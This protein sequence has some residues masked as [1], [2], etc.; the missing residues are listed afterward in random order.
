M[1]FRRCLFEP[2][3]LQEVVFVGFSLHAADKLVHAPVTH[4]SAICMVEVITRKGKNGAY[5]H[6][7]WLAWARCAAAG[8]TV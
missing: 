2:P 1:S 6:A 7:A 8:A 3:A 5:I 4:G